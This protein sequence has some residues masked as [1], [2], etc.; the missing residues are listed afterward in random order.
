MF[1]FKPVTKLVSHLQVSE[2][3]KKPYKYNYKTVLS[4]AS[5]RARSY[6]KSGRTAI[7]PRQTLCRRSV[8]LCSGRRPTVCQRTA[9]TLDGTTA[10]R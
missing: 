5:N 2:T 9:P 1:I 3:Y 8:R 10:P 7:P 4:V 6:E